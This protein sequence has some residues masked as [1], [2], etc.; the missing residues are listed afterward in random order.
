MKEQRKHSSTSNIHRI[1]IFDSTSG[2]GLTGLTSA[3]TGLIISTINDVEASATTYTAAGSGI[4]T[5]AT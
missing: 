2:Q 3:S 1:K 4:E 5:I